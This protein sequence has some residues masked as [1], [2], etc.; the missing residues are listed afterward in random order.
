MHILFT[1]C[2]LVFYN[3]TTFLRNVN[4]FCSGKGLT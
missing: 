4:P 2:G 3:N 1:P